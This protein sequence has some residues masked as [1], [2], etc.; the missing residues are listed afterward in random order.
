MELLKLLW[1]FIPKVDEKDNLV[2]SIYIR[3]ARDTY[4]R[5]INVLYLSIFMYILSYTQDMI[6]LDLKDNI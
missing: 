5:T 1:E 4:T 6:P 2:T 3:D